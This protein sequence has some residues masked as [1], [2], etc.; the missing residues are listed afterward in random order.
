MPIVLG[1]FTSS[2]AKFVDLS[3]CCFFPTSVKSFPEWAIFW[4]ILWYKSAAFSSTVARRLPFSSVSFVNTSFGESLISSGLMASL[5]QVSVLIFFLLFPS[6]V[7]WIVRQNRRMLSSIE[8]D[9]R[10]HSTTG[11]S[12]NVV[13]TGSSYQMYHKVLS[14]CYRERA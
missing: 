3:Y 4:R 7:A 14:F 11:L 8:C 10:H 13:V 12:D 1:T 5:I 9:S 6:A 2:S